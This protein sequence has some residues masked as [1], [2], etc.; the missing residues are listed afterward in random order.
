MSDRWLGE[1]RVHKC[2]TDVLNIALLEFGESFWFRKSYWA[3]IIVSYS[4]IK[5]KNNSEG[6]TNQKKWVKMLKKVGLKNYKNWKNDQE[7]LNKVNRGWGDGN[8]LTASLLR[9]AI[10]IWSFMSQTVCEVTFFS[11]VELKHSVLNL[12]QL[13]LKHVLFS[14]NRLVLPAWLPVFFSCSKCLTKC[15]WK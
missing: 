15:S 14:D 7:I 13:Q 5:H 3:V 4:V 9:S 8:C 10:A 12:F 6:F 1:C 11:E 2:V